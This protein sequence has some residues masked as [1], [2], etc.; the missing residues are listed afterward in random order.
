MGFSPLD[1]QAR[2]A[3]LGIDPGRID[4]LW[5]P[6]TQQ[7]VRIAMAR[8]GVDTPEELFHPSGLQRVV[9]HW[10]AGAYGA[11]ALELRHYHRL[12]MQ[13]GRV[14]AGDH[15]P[16]ANADISDGRYA[17][18]TRALNTGSIGVAVDAM[19]G[20]HQVP[21]DAGTWPVT[22]AQ[23]NGLVEEVADLCATYAIPVSRWTVLTHA[24]VQP[25]LGVWQRQKW[26]ITWLPG[27]DEPGPAVA[28]GDVLRERIRA[29]S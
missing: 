16:E 27:M 5:G 17:V 21:F 22:A 28:V 18:H 6:K 19:G 26:D 3:A 1:Y 25:L 4:G 9:M 14:V 12:I 23:V 20:A 7:A 15:A 2:C 13:D 24:E 8:A 11:I 10:T 29:A